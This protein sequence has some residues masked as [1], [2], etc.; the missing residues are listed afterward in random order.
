MLTQEVEIDET[1]LDP[2]DD[3]DDSTTPPAADEVVITEDEPVI[4]ADL[5][6]PEHLLVK[7]MEAVAVPL[8]DE[9]PVSKKP[10][11][12]SS[13]LIDKPLNIQNALDLS[14]KLDIDDAGA[15]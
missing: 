11:M 13:E 4:G 6:D 2:Q 12:I 14:V 1:T 10:G 15:L 5:N 3:S 7:E 9:G 8:D